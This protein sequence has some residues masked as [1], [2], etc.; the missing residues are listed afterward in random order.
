MTPLFKIYRLTPEEALRIETQPNKPHNHDFEELI[1]GIEGVL[2]HFIDFKTETYTAPFVSFITKG[3][4][5][6]VRP[7]LNND[8]CDMWVIRFASEFIPDTTFRLYSFYHD[9][10]TISTQKGNCFN[11]MAA[12][13]DMMHNEMLA[14]VPDYPVIQHLLSALF[15]MVESERKKIDGENSNDTLKTNN[16]TFKN[17]LALLEENFRRAKGVEFYA[18]KLFMTARS[19]N[20][21][22]QNILQKSVSE[23]IETRKLIEAKNLLIH[24]DKPISE[25]GYELGYNE[26]AYFTSVFK[27]R[28]GQTP[29]QFREEMQ[30]I[31]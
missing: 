1:I 2:E 15:A 7:G 4:I 22:C 29:S 26:K 19:L 16:I 20:L 8:R 28:S 21:I 9:Y 30:K 14:H 6:R 5:H 23:I 25:I 13:C 10:A 31:I 3:K 27:K 17:F 24:T 12:L 11:R 18:S